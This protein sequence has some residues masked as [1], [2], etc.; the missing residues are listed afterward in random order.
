MLPEQP[1]YI[2]PLNLQVCGTQLN[3]KLLQIFSFSSVGLRFGDCEG[4]SILFLQ[5]PYL[6]NHLVNPPALWMRTLPSWRRLLPSC[7]N[8]RWSLL[9]QVGPNHASEISTTDPFTRQTGQTFNETSFKATEV[10][11]SGHVD[12]AVQCS[13]AVW[14]PLHL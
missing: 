9:S 4:H 6:S 14:K 11:T 7:D 1:R 2:L 3:S 13:A 10:L 5:F 8:H 12:A